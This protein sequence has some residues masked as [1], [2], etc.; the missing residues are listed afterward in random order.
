ME[1][2]YWL[3]QKDQ[4]TGP[5]S[6]IQLKGI[7]EIE[8]LNLEC[9]ISKDRNKWIK[10]SE[11][12]TK[13]KLQNNKNNTSNHNKYIYQLEV[14]HS[15]QENGQSA[16]ENAKLV[17]DLSSFEHEV[18]LTANKLEQP[19]NI[20]F[21]QFS[22][23]LKQNTLFVKCNNTK[24]KFFFTDKVIKEYFKICDIW[25]TKEYDVKFNIQYL[26]SN[27]PNELWEQ[28]ILYINCIGFNNWQ[29]IFVYGKLKHILI[30]S[31]EQLVKEAQILKNILSINPENQEIRFLIDKKGID[32]I[33]DRVCKTP[34]IK[35]MSKLW[36]RRI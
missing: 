14:R 11:L 16:W 8:K 22:T 6:K 18:I 3:R 33:Y 17:I 7:I 23:Q 15:I 35:I 36:K 13:R 20:S 26:V 12:K 24:E 29:F 4:V 25:R 19:I 34:K 21:N 28:A 9:E 1:P 32:A 5:Y 2:Q 30:L 10:I 31:M 27:S